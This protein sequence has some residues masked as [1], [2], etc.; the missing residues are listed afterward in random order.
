M[1]CVRSAGTA[2]AQTTIVLNQAGSQVTDT[3]L[4]GGAYAN[5]NYDSQPL[6]TRR[7]TSDPDWERRALLKFDTRHYVPP[8]AQIVSATLTLTVKSGLGSAGQT[9]PL[10]A[11]RVVGAFL[12]GDATWL[13]RM[14]SARWS[15]PGGDVGEHRRRGL[16]SNVA[17]AKVT[18]DV[19]NL[20]QRTSDGDFDTRY[21]RILLVDAGV[22]VEGELPR[23]TYNS[24]DSSA[25][26]RPTLTIVLTSA[27]SPPPGSSSTIKVLQ[28][29]IAQGYGQDGKSNIDRVVDFIVST[30]PDIISFNEIMRYSSSSQPQNDRRQA[31]GQDRPDLDLQVGAEVRFVERR[32]RVRDDAA[33]TSTRPMIT[34]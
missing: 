24:E 22:E 26:R 10:H 18:F 15:T 31:Q 34:F 33:P 17:G 23:V 3:T 16:S 29:N 28:W 14:D 19:T 32:R 27:A 11:Y 5:T 7:S 9:R 13:T 30:R 21:T 2:A 12:E 20:V 1:Q 6:I 25:S 4:R 8:G